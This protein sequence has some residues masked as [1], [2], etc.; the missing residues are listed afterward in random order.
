MSDKQAI[1][2]IPKKIKHEQIKSKNNNDDKIK[3][4]SKKEVQENKKNQNIN[5]VKVLLPWYIKY[6]FIGIWIIILS[7]IFMML[8]SYILFNTYIHW[9]K[10]YDGKKYNKVFSMNLLAQYLNFSLGYDI[11]S[12]FS[13]ELVKIPSNGCA[14][15]LLEYIS[16]FAL[17][18]SSDDSSIYFMMPSHICETIAVGILDHTLIGNG[19]QYEPSKDKGFDWEIDG[20]VDNNNGWPISS[21]SWR[22]LLNYWGI[23]ANPEQTYNYSKW[24]AD[25]NQNFLYHKYKLPGNS[26][27][28]KSFMY[29]NASDENGETL[30]EST[31]LSAVGLNDITGQDVGYYG[32][33]WGMLKYG[34]K[35]EFNLSYA[36]IIR[37]LYEKTEFPS[38]I[39]NQ[40][41]NANE[42]GF[43][44]G[45]AIAGGIATSLSLLPFGTN[46]AGLVA[47]IGGGIFSSLGPLFNTIQKCEM[48]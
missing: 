37:I 7:I 33:W 36:N 24:T 8:N 23:P 40:K 30:Y 46:P 19:A 9:W 38:N 44:Y 20:Y 28:I 41:C 32:G 18:S 15:F 4:I 29:G 34:F 48:N 14:K 1:V 22:K 2:Y 47:I 10:L 45:S 11:I 17:L 25:G 21:L 6:F 12:L 5:T 42:R 35:E 26:L 3:Y 39:S 16:A 43:G 13:S 27:F 31:F